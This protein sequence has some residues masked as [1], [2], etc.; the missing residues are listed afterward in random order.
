MSVLS[1]AVATTSFAVLPHLA[2]S[3]QERFEAESALSA[4]YGAQVQAGW[5]AVMRMASVA[6]MREEV[7]VLAEQH[8]RCVTGAV[9][10]LRGFFDCC[11][12]S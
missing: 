11:A 1:D 6:G 4:R 12:S 7:E 8:E 5:R 2:F 10:D 9:L 3:L